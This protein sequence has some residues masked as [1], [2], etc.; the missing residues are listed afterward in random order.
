M[1]R[2]KKGKRNRSCRIAWVLAAAL[3]LTAVNIPGQTVRVSAETPYEAGRSQ[4][5]NV[6]IQITNQDGASNDWSG[7]DMTV[8]NNTGQSICDWVIELTVPNGTADKF[9]CWNA[10]FVADGNTIRLYPAK[11]GNNAVLAPG[12]MSAN[13]PGGGFASAYVA[14]SDIKMTKVSYNYGSS[15]TFDYSSGQTNDENAGGG[16]GSGSS[17][18]D[19]TTDKDLEIEYNYA[20]LLQESLYFYDANMCGPQVDDNCALSWRS[21]CHTTDSNVSFTQNGKTYTVDVSGGFH[22]A[23]DHVKFGLPQ[24][25]AA[26]AL[27]L[28]YYA[29]EDAY[30]ELDQA[31][32]LQ[33]ITNYFCDYFRR[34]T[35][36]EGGEAIAFCYQVGE[37]GPDHGYW[38][39]P[40]KQTGERKA[41]FATSSN[42][43]TDEVSIA[44]A[45]LAVNYLN[46]GREE[47]LETAK[48]LFAFAKKN[49]KAC[50][51]E[52]VGGFYDSGSWKDDYAVAAAALYLA[53]QDNMYQTEY[54]GNKDSVNPGWSLGWNDTGIMAAVLMKEWGTVGQAAGVYNSAVILD[55]VYSCLDDWGSCRHNASMQFVALMY[56]KN[57]T[58]KYKD[59]AGSQMRY[60]L[61]ENPNKRCYVVGYNANSSKYP[62]HRAASRSEDAGSVREDH[63]TLVGALVGGPKRDGTYHDSQS[64]YIANEVALD[65]N[66]GL[67]GAA[68]GLYLAYKDTE[69][70][71]HSN[72]LAAKEELEAVG[73]TKYYGDPEQMGTPGPVGTSK[74]GQSSEPD[75]TDEPGMTSQPG[76]SDTP[77]TTG[78]PG[79]SIE[80]GTT[81]QPGGSDTPG[82]TTQPGQSGEPGSSEQPSGS[83]AP[84]GTNQPGTS[85]AP[86]T[87]AQPGTSSSPLV[88]NTPLP[89]TTP[90]GQQYGQQSGG[91]KTKLVLKK[92]VL[93]IKVGKKARIK[94]KKKAAG[95]KVK[96]YRIKG[97]KIVKVNKKGVVKG[98]RKG[99]TKVVVIM[100]SGARAVCKI[101]VK[102]R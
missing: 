91:K 15:S 45:A 59:W 52:G 5:G 54:A 11:D 39:P 87:T 31:G 81:N 51:T 90:D 101:I 73:V 26:T 3:V 36:M 29:F 77:G 20:K 76:G 19:S 18:T 99:R 17:A 48:A 96:K 46:F 10:T 82:T 55:G 22:D 42:P 78:Q 23:G 74:P 80:P 69:L 56:D 84:G 71:S 34:S 50:A 58:P 4:S 83:S 9:K 16:G 24:G 98:K 62:H 32:H 57:N 12:A 100:K 86:G 93:K 68:A 63:Y 97:R 38:G 2:S 44:A 6:D 79:Q 64:D 37:G 40:E 7:F 21:A 13:T 43:A 92:K 85:S 94:I 66:A 8:T 27:G 72:L 88:I 65:Y 41:F 67:V 61:G 102:K 75:E 30:T 49:S 28:S 53:T 1:R 70:P 95:D 35:V 47:D 89:A 33:T 60:I 14:A 25:Y